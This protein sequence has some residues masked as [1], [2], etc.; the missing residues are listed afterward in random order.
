MIYHQKSSISKLSKNKL[1]TDD[2]LSYG[3]E[4][5]MAQFLSRVHNFEVRN[6]TCLF[7][8]KKYET[9]GGIVESHIIFC[10]HHSV[11]YLLFMASL[12]IVT[13]SKKNISKLWSRYTTVNKHLK[14][15]N[16][17]VYILSITLSTVFKEYRQMV[18]VCNDITL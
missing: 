11:N 3:R 4:C 9:N 12:K 14:S 8:V 10:W 15:I 16:A 17:V 13:I 6:C 2:M 1:W 7:L 18:C 5:Q